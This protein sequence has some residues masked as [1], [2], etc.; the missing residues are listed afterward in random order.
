[1]TDAELEETIRL[2]RVLEETLRSVVLGV[3]SEADGE[4]PAAGDETQQVA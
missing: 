4:L 1:M 3:K 2:L